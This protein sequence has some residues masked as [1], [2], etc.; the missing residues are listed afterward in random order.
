MADITVD[1]KALKRVAVELAE[2]SRKDVPKAIVSAINRTAQG[3]KTDMRRE[4]VKLYEIK[5]GDVQKTLKL[6]RASV[7]SMNAVATSAGRPLGLFHFKVKPRKR[8][9]RKIK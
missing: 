3:V 8:P 4:A 6:K 1:T 2:V 7:S 9:T 5:S